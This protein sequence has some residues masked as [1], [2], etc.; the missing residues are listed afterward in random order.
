M[1]MMNT[2]TN[3]RRRGSALLAVI[4]F[5]AILA[6]LGSS[7]LAVDMQI[8]KSRRTLDAEQQ[9]FFAAEAGINEVYVR[10]QTRL[11]DPAVGE[12]AALGS[13]EN[14]MQLGRAS[15]WATAERL[16]TRR[17][18]ITATGLHDGVRRRQETVLSFA[19]IGLFQ[20]AAYGRNGVDVAA[21]SFFDS[22]DSI[23]GDYASQ[24]VSGVDHARQNAVLGSNGDIRLF[25]NTRVYGDARPGESGSV[26]ESGS[27]VVITGS[28]DPETEPIV[29]PPIEIPAITS[30][31]PLLVSADTAIGPGRL[32]YDQLTVDSG[33]LTIT[34][35]ATVTME[36]FLLMGGATLSFDTTN[37]PVEVYSAGDW[38]MRS[39]SMLVTNSDSAV[40]V[41]IF[42]SGDTSPGPDS[43]TI[44]LNANAQMRGAIYAPNASVSL[45]SNF[46]IFGSVM[47]GEL[48]LASNSIIHF[49]EALLYDTKK[50][51]REF[52]TLLWRPVARDEGV[53]QQ[54]QP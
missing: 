2:K 3:C 28:R 17:F 13:E 42:L 49:D 41:Q 16:D 36:D 1:H 6:G 40:D 29:L 30:S 19:P 12:T 31:G 18:R 7:M 22:Y 39:N 14:P 26:I 54:A 47:A 11:S 20:Y 34:G 37:G 51:I 27:G 52:E 21:N 24:V 10:L 4:A 38:D 50:Q 15:Y 9:A 48:D 44:G 35:P 8:G 33:T 53:V 23:L 32:G 45:P 46:E 5:V 43:A 25:S